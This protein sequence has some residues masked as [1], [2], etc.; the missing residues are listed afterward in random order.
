MKV[1]SILN[2]P[3]D[4]SHQHMQG[5]LKIIQVDMVVPP[6]RDQIKPVDRV[7]RR[8]TWFTVSGREN[9]SRRKEG[10]VIGEPVKSHVQSH[11]VPDFRVACRATVEVERV[12]RC[13]GGRLL[14]K[15]LRK[16]MLK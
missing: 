11:V 1:T 15:R 5:R 12:V 10:G 9:F 16:L 7:P 13:G 3:I 6:M 4:L 14:G 8:K 2:R